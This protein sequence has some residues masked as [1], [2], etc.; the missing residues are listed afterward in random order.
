MLVALDANE[1]RELTESSVVYT[2]ILPI[3]NMRKV[4]SSLLYGLVWMQHA[5]D[6]YPE[7]RA[8]VDWLRGEH[9]I[10][11]Y[12][13]KGTADSSSSG[14]GNSGKSGS[15]NEESGKEESESERNSRFDEYI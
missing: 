7:R 14:S 2:L 4:D 12:L 10:I 15:G 5:L 1:K 3:G 8:L 9:A 6:P 13:E 11:S